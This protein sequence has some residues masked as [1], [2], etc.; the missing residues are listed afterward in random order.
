MDLFDDR[1]FLLLAKPAVKGSIT[2][3]WAEKTR[4][5]SRLAAFVG[6]IKKAKQQLLQEHAPKGAV[7]DL[8]PFSRLAPINN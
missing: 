7:F 6:W 2:S 3:C 8:T 4:K 1:Q 5:M